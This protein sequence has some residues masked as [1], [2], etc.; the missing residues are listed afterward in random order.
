[1]PDQNQVELE[2]LREERETHKEEQRRA[3]REKQMEK[4]RAARKAAVLR[5][6]TVAFSGLPDVGRTIVNKGKKAVISVG[7]KLP[8]IVSRI[9]RPF[10]VAYTAANALLR[11]AGETVC[12]FAARPFSLPVYILL[13]AAV[14]YG[15]TRLCG[16]DPLFLQAHLATFQ[17]YLCDYSV[18]FCTRLFVGAVIA[19]F[20]DKVSVALMSV[21]IRTAVIA[22]LSV[23][24]VMVGVFSR[25]ACKK[26]SVFAAL[27]GVL[28]LTDPLIVV[29]HMSAPGLLDPYL[30]LVFFAWLA[31]WKTPFRLISTP[32]V[33]FVGMAI[34]YEFLFMYLPPMLTL[35]LY[36]AVFA[37]K[38]TARANGWISLAEGSTVSAA[39]TV[40]FVFFFNRNLKMTADEFFDH[41]ISRF[42]ATTEEMGRYTLLMGAPIFR[43]YFDYNIF[44]ENPTY[45]TFETPAEFLA[46]MRTW[47]A[48]HFSAR[49][50]WASFSVAAGVLVI[51]LVFW[52]ICAIREKGWRRVPYLGFA[53]QTLVLIPVLLLSTDIWRWMM[54]AMISQMSVFIAVYLDGDAVLHGITDNK[55]IPPVIVTLLLFGAVAYSSY[56]I[57][58][59]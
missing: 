6:F 21:I 12:R 51:P 1:M 32:V 35:L 34:H 57:T 24:A 40:Y 45:G 50:F 47:A 25:T 44:G 48:T 54:A 42:D 41:M 20:T 36:D 8:G 29:G 30:Q 17:F 26:R 28:F 4:E 38:K 43:E 5:L 3:A 23:Q 46:M 31:L 13:A 55:R 18:G 22:A 56:C 11:K 19:L 37:N 59:L 9:S 7:E 39:L 10:K 52:V 14:Y 27:L 33:C 2:R 49:Q 53:A 15:I 16:F 58:L